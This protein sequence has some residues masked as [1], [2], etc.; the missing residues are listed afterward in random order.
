MKFRNLLMTAAFVLAVTSTFA[1]KSQGK[2]LM[3]FSFTSGGTCYANNDE[4]DQEYCES[5][6]TG[7]Q[8][9]YNTQP[10]FYYDE[11]GFPPPTCSLPLRRFN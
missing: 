5:F 9:T 8:C 2:A 3:W 10:I 7:A 6:F 11:T 4:T 1:F